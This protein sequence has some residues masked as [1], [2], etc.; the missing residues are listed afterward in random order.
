MEDIDWIVLIAG[1]YMF[2]LLAVFVIHE[3]RHW[4]QVREDEHQADDDYMNQTK[5]V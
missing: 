5:D 4:K 1:I 3:R 2:V